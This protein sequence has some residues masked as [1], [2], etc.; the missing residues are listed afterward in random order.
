MHKLD[1]LEKALLIP[2]LVGCGI[3][4]GSQIR[5]ETSMV[6]SEI[7]HNTSAACALGF[8]IRTWYMEEKDGHN[9]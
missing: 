5:N 3:Y 4:I 9:E 1:K 7:A 8:L 2:A 6:Y